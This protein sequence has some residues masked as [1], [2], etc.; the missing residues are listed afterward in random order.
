M[1]PACWVTQPQLDSLRRLTDKQIDVYLMPGNRDFL[2][3][4][5]FSEMTGVTILP[6]P[7]RIEL[8]GKQVLLK[9]GDDLCTDDV[10]HQKFRLMTRDPA[11]QQSVLSKAIDERLVMASQLRQMSGSNY[12]PS[13]IMDVNQDCIRQTFAEHDVD[14]LIHGHTHRPGSHDYS[15]SGRFRQ[16]IVLGDW[17]KGISYLKVDDLGFHLVHP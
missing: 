6:D 12:K 13:E 5:E 17:H 1:A 4:Q 8:I 9:H 11:W 16:R 7:T 14:V 15:I 10:E 3:G 2:V